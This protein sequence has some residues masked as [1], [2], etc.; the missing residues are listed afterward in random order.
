M[1]RRS[2]DAAQGVWSEELNDVPQWIELVEDRVLAQRQLRFLT[3]SQDHRHLH[4]G[5]EANRRATLALPLRWN[6]YQPMSLVQDESWDAKVLH[7][8]LT[9]AKRKDAAERVDLY[10]IGPA[11]PR[12]PGSHR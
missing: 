1:P 6:L 2:G 5:D 9:T 11:R 7:F 3:V 8:S 10:R 12:S 4:V